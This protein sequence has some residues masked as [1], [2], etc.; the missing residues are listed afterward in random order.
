MVEIEKLKRLIDQSD[1]VDFADFGNGVSLVWINKA[2]DYLGFS[3]PDSYKWWL[4]NYGGGEICGEEIYSIYEQDFEDV[5]G[6]DIVHMYEINLTHKLLTEG[7]VAISES[8]DGDEF[9]F[10]N[11]NELKNGE[12]PIYLFDRIN[13]I[14]EKYADD[15]LE[16]LFKRIQE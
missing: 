1:L 12:T 5:S 9:F 3:L 8:A 16:F 7:N 6:G 11:L 15:F 14:E 13:S 4:L 10:F 2:E